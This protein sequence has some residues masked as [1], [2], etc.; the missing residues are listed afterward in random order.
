MMS[1]AHLSKQRVLWQLK[2]T[3]DPIAV[4]RYRIRCNRFGT[5]L[6]PKRRM[7]AG[8]LASCRGT[9]ARSPGTIAI[10]ITMGREPPE[11]AAPF[12]F[13]PTPSGR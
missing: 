8:G 13:T 9:G 5:R 7:G 12:A 2:S 3:T 1:E 11:G 4:V 6:I 10:G